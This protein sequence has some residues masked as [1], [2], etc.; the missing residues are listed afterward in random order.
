LT[1]YLV[2]VA[3]SNAW[4]VFRSLDT[5]WDL[6]S[7]HAPNVPH[8]PFLALGV[9]SGI[10]VIGVVG[11]WLLKK[12]GLFLYLICWTSALGIGIFLGVPFRAHLLSLVNV[13]LLY[14]FL[15]PRRDLLR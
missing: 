12:W 5:Y 7:H 6:V 4:G 2:Y 10:A 13:V 8:W 3:L 9:V 11:L 1:A 15:E 14:L